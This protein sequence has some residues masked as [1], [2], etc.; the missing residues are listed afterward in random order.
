MRILTNIARVNTGDQWKRGDGFLWHIGS[1]ILTV[2]LDTS[3]KGM[4]AIL[5]LDVDQ[6]RPDLQVRHAPGRERQYTYFG[7]QDVILWGQ[8]LVVR[9][10]HNVSFSG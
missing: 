2:D 4:R 1:A 6:L 9:R 3:C 8:D 7:R 5:T 10:L